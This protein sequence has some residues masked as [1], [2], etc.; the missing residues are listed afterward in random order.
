MERCCGQAAMVHADHVNSWWGVELLIPL[1]KHT[2]YYYFCEL[3]MCRPMPTRGID[4][5]KLR[6]V[7]SSTSIHFK[8]S[9]YICTKCL[10]HWCAVSARAFGCTRI[11][12]RYKGH[13]WSENDIIMSC[14][15]LIFIS[16][17]FKH[18]Y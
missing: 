3:S 8:H 12:L 15:R 2:K 14:S 6:L 17:H 10:S 16:D 1:L 18:S 5:K 9:Y 4:L 13:L 7:I 11:L